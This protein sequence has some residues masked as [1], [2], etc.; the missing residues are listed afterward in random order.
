M[1]ILSLEDNMERVGGGFGDRR[2]AAGVLGV[3]AR[4]EDPYPNPLPRVEGEEAA[5]LRW[6]V[7]RGLW[8]AGW[9]CGRSG[10]DV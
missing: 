7:V 9:G 2:A 10:W 4:P 8:V 6:G 1:A 5:A 3:G